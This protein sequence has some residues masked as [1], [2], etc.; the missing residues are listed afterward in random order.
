MDD[1]A[2]FFLP[3]CLIQQ[4]MLPNEGRPRPVNSA[5]PL[6]PQAREVSPDELR[7]RRPQAENGVQGQPQ[8]P[9]VWHRHRSLPSGRV[10]APPGACRAP[11]V[12]RERARLLSS[13]SL[14]R[15][16]LCVRGPEI[17]GDE[18]AL[19]LLAAWEEKQRNPQVPCHSRQLSRLRGGPEEDT[20]S[21]ARGLR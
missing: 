19:R 4:T 2:V 13:P 18:P 7:L 16:W 21:F 17:H 10:S 20:P 15:L 6:P 14:Q 3:E 11:W 1:S 8:T 12:L 9:A 5:S